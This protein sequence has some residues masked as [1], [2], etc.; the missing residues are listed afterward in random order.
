MVVNRKP[1]PGTLNKDLLELKNKLKDFN[2][3]QISRCVGE[4]LSQKKVVPGQSKKPKAVVTK[5]KGKC[6]RCSVMLKVLWISLIVFLG[7]GFMAVGFKP[8]AFLVHKVRSVGM[9]FW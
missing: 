7:L 5:P 1:V 3:E 6:H 9:L 2:V 4:A 8:V